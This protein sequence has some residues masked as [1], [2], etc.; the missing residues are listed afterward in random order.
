[1]PDPINLNAVVSR[2]RFL[3]GG[4]LAGFAAFLA[5]CGTNGTGGSPSAG[6]ATPTAGLP[7]TGASPTIAP[8][9]ATP[10]AELNWANWCCYLD[11]DP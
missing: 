5:A 10:S 2:R 3:A 7:S 1:M 4:T 8:V 11:V 6:A 9:R